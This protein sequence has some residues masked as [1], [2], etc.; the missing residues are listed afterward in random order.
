MG[1]YQLD[2]TP[3]QRSDPVTG[4]TKQYIRKGSARQTSDRLEEFHS[5]VRDKLQGTTHQGGDAES[6]ARETRNAFEQAAESC[7]N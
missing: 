7:G 4:E 2:F 3:Y 6:N 5:C 1:E